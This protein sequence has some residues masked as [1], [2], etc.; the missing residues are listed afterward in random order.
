M[1]TL[2]L[3]HPLLYKLFHKIVAR[4]YKTHQKK[5]IAQYLSLCIEL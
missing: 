5:N 1:E 3:V 4:L 2:G